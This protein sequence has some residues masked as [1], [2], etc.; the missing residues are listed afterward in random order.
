MFFIQIMKVYLINW[1]F[2]ANWEGFRII[3]PVGMM[4]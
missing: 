2:S 3:D 4:S 1:D